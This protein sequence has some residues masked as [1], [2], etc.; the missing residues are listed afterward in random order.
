MSAITADAYR[1]VS[2]LNGLKCV[3][4]EL[5][6]AP[7]T[8]AEMEQEYQNGT[9]SR[10]I[11]RMYHARTSDP[12]AISLDDYQHEIEQSVQQAEDLQ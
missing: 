7:F 5:R 10:R 6:S 9:V 1:E 12:D 4:L 2:R 11:G 8:D 3:E